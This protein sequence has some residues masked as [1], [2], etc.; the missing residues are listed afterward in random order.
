MAIHKGI[1]IHQ[2]L[3]DRLVRARSHQTCLQH[4]QELIKTS[5][6]LGWLVNFE[7]SELDSK[8]VF[9]FVGY[10][11]VLKGDQ[12]WPTPKRWQILLQKILE[13]LSRPACPIWQFISLIGLLTATEKQVDLSRLHT[14]PIQ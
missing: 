5:Q 12:F 8:Q 4:T 11:F 10:Q 13:L 9:D 6:K 2:Y 7:K 14:R 1:R 3:D